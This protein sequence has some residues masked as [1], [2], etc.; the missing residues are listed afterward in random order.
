M[1]I[2][3]EKKWPGRTCQWSQ[4]QYCWE[5]EKKPKTK[6]RAELVSLSNK[7]IQNGGGVKILSWTTL[8]LNYDI[9]YT[10]CTC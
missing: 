9:F 7:I 5:T 2:H 6:W 1:A 10:L 8:V 4:L 3:K